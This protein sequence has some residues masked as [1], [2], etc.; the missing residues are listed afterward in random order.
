MVAQSATNV[1][2][3]KIIFIRLRDGLSYFE[4][5]QNVVASSMEGKMHSLAGIC[6]L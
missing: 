4:E 2:M 1:V 5:M 3:G 6:L